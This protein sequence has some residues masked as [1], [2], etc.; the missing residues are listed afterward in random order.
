MVHSTSTTATAASPVDVR[1]SSSA[2]ITSAQ[3]R[4]PTANIATPSCS[5]GAHRRVFLIQLMRRRPQHVTQLRSPTAPAP[6]RPTRPPSK[7]VGG[8]PDDRAA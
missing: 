1:A 2:T 6:M 5:A 4:R 3:S 8:P 7:T